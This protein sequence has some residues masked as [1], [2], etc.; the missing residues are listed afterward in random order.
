M[1]P[2]DLAHF[3]LLSIA[4]TLAPGPDILLV[5]TVGLTQGQRRALPLAWGMALG[6]SVHTALVAGG[7]AGLLAASPWGLPLLRWL[8]AAY[9]CAL[10]LR[11]L[12]R[13]GPA[14]GEEGGGGTE[15]DQ[16]LVWFRRGILMNLLNPKVLVFFL[17]FLPQFLPAEAR[18]P[19]VLV[20]L[21]GSLFIAQTLVIFSLV[22]LL[23]AWFG[24][25]GQRVL[26]LGRWGSRVTGLILLGLGLHLIFANLSPPVG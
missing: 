4:L 26:R 25:R 5:A 9:L 21:L 18:H 24:R 1:A 19:A 13:P 6:N 23:A 12:L 2:P 20:G 22:A 17:A 15:A 3:L 16:P 10:G 7:M 11:A 8:G 14:T